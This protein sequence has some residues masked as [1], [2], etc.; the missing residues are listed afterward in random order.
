MLLS[1]GYLKKLMSHDSCRCWKKLN[2]PEG[3]KSVFV[4]NFVRLSVGP[5]NFIMQIIDGVMRRWFR[6]DF[7]SSSS[8]AFKF[9]P[10]QISANQSA[11]SNLL[12]TARPINDQSSLMKIKSLINPTIN[13]IVMKSL[14]KAFLNDW[15]V[16]IH[17]CLT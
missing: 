17:V 13:F 6:S 16:C 15:C 11:D 1:S 4:N 7:T 12:L 3:I 10:L 14:S 9:S 5:W 8:V 2:T